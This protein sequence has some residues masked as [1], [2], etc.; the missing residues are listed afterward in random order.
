M[1]LQLCGFNGARVI[2]MVAIAMCFSMSSAYTR[3][4][5]LGVG[6]DDDYQPTLCCV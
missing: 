4:D 6:E 3:S 1:V 2:G 5:G